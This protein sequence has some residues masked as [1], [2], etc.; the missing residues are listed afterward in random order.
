MCSQIRAKGGE[1]LNSWIN[2]NLIVT[3]AT[4]FDKVLKLGAQFDDIFV[5]CHVAHE[6]PNCAQ[7]LSQKGQLCVENAIMVSELK[8]E[9]IEAYDTK[10]KELA[11]KSGLEVIESTDEV[12]KTHFILFGNK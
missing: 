6:I 5:G 9:Q 11:L 12:R 1:D 3:W 10:I 4:G 2:E 8:D 7:L